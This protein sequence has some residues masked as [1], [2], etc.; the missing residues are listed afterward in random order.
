MVPFKDSLRVQ[1]TV[2]KATDRPLIARLCRRAVGRSDY[3][4]RIL[5]TVIARRGLFLAWAGNALV[6]MT[7]F[8]TCMDGTGWLSI[9]R[10]DPDWRG[11][12][13]ATFLQREISDYARRIGIRTLRLWVLSGNKPSLRACERGGFKQVCEAAHVACNLRTRTPRRRIRPSYPSEGQ[14]RSLLKSDFLAKTEGYIGYGRHFMKLTEGL[15]ERVRDQAELYWIEDSA[16]LVSKPD[17]TFG[18]PQSSLT[19]LHGTVAESLSIGKKIAHGLSARIL[20][21]YTPYRSY[22]LSVARGSD[23]RRSSWG[24]HCLVFERKV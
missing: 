15:L 8:D 24:K 16:L 6:G 19:I 17:R 2:G 5:P 3:V 11:R 20:N 13:V 22:E 12:G 21:C 23:F 18:T 14:L 9:A 10:T 4:L 7:N 1:I